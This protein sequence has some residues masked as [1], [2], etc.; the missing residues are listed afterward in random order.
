[1]NWPKSSNNGKIQALLISPHERGKTV[2]NDAVFPFPSLTLPILAGAFPKNYSVRIKDE[3]ISRIKGK[4]KADI[5]FITTLTSTANRAYK[6]AEL[7]RTRGI[8]VVIG[9]V[10]A[11]ILPQEAREH[12]TSIVIGEAEGIVQ[13][14]LSDFE[15]GRLAPIYRSPGLTD[16]ATITNPSLQLLSW[17]HRFFIS[18][19]QTSRGCPNTCDFCSVPRISGRKLRLKSLTEIEKELVYL[20]RFRSRKLFVVDDNFT[21]K[22]DR[23]LQL[24]ALFQKFGFR[25]MAFSNLS[26]SEDD[27]YMAA[28]A[29]S[30]CISLFIGFESLRVQDHLPKNRAYGTPE[31]MAQAVDRI[32][33]H[34]I[35]IQGSFIFGFDSDTPE[36][37]HETVS[38]IQDTEIEL[39]HMCILTPFPGTPLF[40]ALDSKGRIIHKDW[41][42]Y[43]MNHVVFRPQNMSPEVLQQ[44]Y[45]W[46][47]KYLSSPTSIFAR[48]KKKSAAR[49][50]FLTANFSLHR[51]Q[52]RLARSLWNTRIQTLMQERG[53]C[54]C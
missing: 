20:S 6:L 2:S 28:L 32:H 38:F 9:G 30:G 36:V 45:A 35:G 52:T 41:S 13:N 12:A 40:D 47:L 14:I 39:P 19:L 15:K 37:F 54:P 49:L 24:M 27:A 53:Q 26:V 18:P 48:I 31:A 11:T 44:G 1:M 46:S 29:D 34:G 10:H 50:Y 16:L 22:R 5:I 17:R 23:S 25:W 43:D 42:C 21:L 8:P 7:F 3:K 33:E 51:S 4:E